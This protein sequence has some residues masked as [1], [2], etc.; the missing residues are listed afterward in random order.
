MREGIRLVHYAPLGSS[1]PTHPDTMTVSTAFQPGQRVLSDAEPELGLGVVEDVTPRQVTVAFPASDSRRTYALPSPP[2]HRLRFAPGDRITLR[3]GTALVV[4]SVEEADGILIYTGRTPEGTAQTAPETELDDHLRLDRPRDRLLAGRIDSEHWYRLRRE[5]RE[6]QARQLPSPVWGLAGA[7][8]DLIPHQLYIAHEVANRPLPRVLLADEVG[9]GKTIEAG[10]I[11]HRLV[12]GGRVRR[13]LILV[14]DALVHQWLVEMRHRFHLRFALFDAERCDALAE[15]GENPFQSEQLV[16]ASLGLFLEAPSRREQATACDWDLIVVDEAHHLEWTP[17]APSDAYRFVEALAARAPG[18][19]LLSATPEQLGAAGHFARLRLL[20]P[21]RFHD[22]DAFLAEEERYRPVARAAAALLDEPVLP[23]D[24]RDTLKTTFRDDPEALAWIDTVADATVDVDTR[25]EARDRLLQRLL[26]Q[27]GTGRVLFRNTR[28]H[29]KGFPLRELRPTP[30]PWPAEYDVIFEVFADDEARERF[31]AQLQRPWPRLLLTPEVI[32][33]TL[34]TLE[35]PALAGSR[36]WWRCD[37]R[38]GWLRQTLRALRGEKVLVI[39][40]DAQTAIDL[41]R[42]LRQREGLRVAAFHEGMKLLERDRAAA[43]FADQEDG[44]QA[45]ICS[46]IGSEGRNFQFA[47]HLVLF[48]LPAHPDLLEQRIGRLDRIGQKETIRIHVP[49]LQESAQA[50]QF[51]WYHEGLDAFLHTCPA[52]PGVYAEVQERLDTLLGQPHP[53]GDAIDAL[54]AATRPVFERIDRTLKEGR[55]RLLE[56]NAYRPDVAK[57]LVEAIRAQDADAVLPDYL[58]RLA[59]AFGVEVEEHSRDNL[60]LR[61]GDHMQV[62]HFPE[63]G[64]DGATLC[65][66]RHAALVHEDRL[67]ITWEHPMVTGALELLL[68]SERGNTALSLCKLPGLPTG[69]LLL[70]CLYRVDCVAPPALEVFR[71]LPPQVIPVLLDADG[72]DRLGQW[73]DDQLQ[74]LP[75]QLGRDTVQQIIAGYQERLRDLLERAERLAAE[76][77]PATVDAARERMERELGEE[78]ERLRQLQKVNPNVRDEEIRALENRRAALRDAF[79]RTH[80]R[81]DAVRVILA[82]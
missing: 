47:H 20:D 82:A 43:W 28:E 19:L 35:T 55:D 6:A 13:A 1:L 66:D 71:F 57:P 26:D 7:R 30:L 42:V 51:R 25:D 70:E 76:R 56:L 37:P 17:A 78:I 46:E 24:A 77:L 39:C 81:L 14:P 3:D 58:V 40:A 5:G 10:L 34:Q 33:R 32:Y 62:H 31:A 54:L 27:H 45:L 60:I 21:H 38:V 65:F 23:A 49:W 36:P 68:E 75:A 15:G 22:L 74:G 12:L 8:I 67:F 4:T 9:L 61:P 52:G 2:L 73:R 44:A 11:L 59:D 18:V 53:A 63:L 16:L 69:A 29:V 50:V 79:A 72:R 48:D 64:E 80:V 41:E